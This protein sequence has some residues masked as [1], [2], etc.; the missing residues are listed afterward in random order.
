MNGKKESTETKVRNFVDAGLKI[1]KA[2]E[3]NDPELQNPDNL[4]EIK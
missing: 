4:A 3:A 1:G 2:I